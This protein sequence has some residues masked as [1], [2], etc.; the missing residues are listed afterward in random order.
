MSRTCDTCPFLIPEWDPHP[1]CVSH[2]S[3][4]QGSPCQAFCIGLAKE[5]W[6]LI[7]RSSA[8]GLRAR[9]A[10][11]STKG[12][13]YARKLGTAASTCLA[14]GGEGTPTASATGRASAAKMDTYPIPLSCPGYAVVG[15]HP[16]HCPSLRPWRMGGQCCSPPRP[17]AV[18]YLPIALREG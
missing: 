17:Q 15:H 8:T 18:V 10:K 5:H 6:K 9:K 4:T 1:S 7:T 12:G 13:K 14:S 16:S 3:C 2:R 11:E